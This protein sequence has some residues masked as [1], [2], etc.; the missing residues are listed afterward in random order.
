MLSRREMEKRDRRCKERKIKRTKAK[1][2][3]RSAETEEIL[4]RQMIPPDANTTSAYHCENTPIQ[5]NIKF[6]LQKLKIFR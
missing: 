4:K 5:I 6:H 2:N 3:D 1:V